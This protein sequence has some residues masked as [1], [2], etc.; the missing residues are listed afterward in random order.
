M[1]KEKGK[2]VLWAQYFDVELTQSEGRR[3][4]KK[5][6]LQSPK[7]EEIQRTAR[8]LGY[9]AIIDPDVAYPRHWW[10]KTGRVII[11]GAKKPKSKVILEV[12][13]SIKERA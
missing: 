7:I 5:L 12:A 3:V 1:P 11:D 13:K 6:A 2:M 10:K 9:D 4:P 8:G